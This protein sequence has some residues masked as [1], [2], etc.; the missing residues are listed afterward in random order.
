MASKGGQ[1]RKIAI[2]G[3]GG[4][5]K[6]TITA[7]IAV[8]LA[9]QSYT[10]MQIGCDPKQDSTMNLVGGLIIPSILELINDFGFEN[11][12]LED[13]CFEG[14]AG[15]I[16]AE[17]GGPEPGI[18]CAGRGVIT[19]LTF[20]KEK[21]AFEAY[22]VEVVI[23]DVLGDVVCGGFAMPLREGFANE[24]YIV[25]SAEIMSLYAANNI[26]L[27]IN[28][29]IQQGLPLVLGG[30]IAVS[31]N[32][33]SEFNLIDKFASKI[34]VPV[35]AQIPRSLEVQRAE[36]Q[37]KTVMQYAPYSAQAQIYFSLSQKIMQTNT[38]ELKVAQPMSR[39]TFLDW[40]KKESTSLLKVGN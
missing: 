22:D 19:A 31:R 14:A 18:G 6:S 9:Q 39:L 23:F 10:V 13:C 40:Y 7:N 1:M 15:V 28:R 38:K 5:G 33:P 37:G 20:L 21:R 30:L 2:Y 25:T 32:V 35:L 36:A 24:V 12:A 34:N 26:V 8:A 17:A 11:V 3:K 29:F 4:I 27:A 16:A